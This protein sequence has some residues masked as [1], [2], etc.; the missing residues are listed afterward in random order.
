MRTDLMLDSLE[1]TLC[2]RTPTQ[3]VV[4]HGDRGSRY[5]SLRYT[6][7]LAEA[8]AMASV[9]S[10]GDC[11]DNAL[12]ETIIGVYKTEVIR[13]RDSWHALKQVE[14]ATLEGV[15]WFKNRRLLSQLVTCLLQG[16]KGQP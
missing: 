3:G 13:R 16:W 6:G 10:V 5:L 7:R 9:G 1:Q 11:Y 15:D 14:Y 2:C 4:H 12:A 8:G